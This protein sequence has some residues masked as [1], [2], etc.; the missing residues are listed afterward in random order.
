MNDGPSFDFDDLETPDA[1][2]SPDDLAILQ[3]FEA[4]QDWEHA[5][6]PA[7]VPEA[8]ISEEESFDD[9]A[10]EMLMLFIS[11]VEE[12]IA[13]MQHALAAL[14]QEDH[15]QPAHYLTLHRAG[16]KI[17]GTAG[18]ME[19]H[20]MAAI[21]HYVE[22]IV[23][24]I[25]AG[26]IF[27]LIGVRALTLA[28]QAME[29]SLNSV[30]L[31]GKEQDEPLIHFKETLAQLNIQVEEEQ[32]DAGIDRF[33]VSDGRDQPAIESASQHAPLEQAQEASSPIH[34]PSRLAPEP[35]APH[36]FVRV[37]MHRFEQL[38]HHTEH[39]AE[40]RSPLESA[41]A[42]VDEALQELHEAQARLHRL[43]D[44][45]SAL[46][47][48][49]QHSHEQ[50]E[51]PHTALVAPSLI[52]KILRDASQRVDASSLHHARKVKARPRLTRMSGTLSWDE[53]EIERYTEH[54]TLTRALNEAI[55]DVSLA[56]SRVRIAFTQLNTVLQHYT[57]RSATV[58]N[59]MLRLRLAPLSRLVPR[60]QR[61]ITMSIMP[62]QQQS[63]QFEVEGETTEVD[64]DTL[65]ALT[66][67]LLQLL[68]TCIIDTRAVQPGTEAEEAAKAERI[69]LHARGIGNEILIELGFSMPVVY[70]D[71]TAMQEE[72]QRLKGTMS[73]QAL[74]SGG[75]LF[76]LRLPRS[77][78]AVRC[79]LVR[80]GSQHLIVPF[81]QVLRIADTQRE[82]FDTLFAFHDLL[83]LPP[84]TTNVHP[85]IQPAL[86]LPREEGQ[87]SI[88]VTV[89]E[90]VNDVELIVKPLPPYLQ[91][92]GIVDA[93][94]DGKGQ[95]LLMADLP[96]LIS[97]ERTQRHETL[98]IAVRN[99]W[100]GPQ[101]GRQLTVLIADDSASM[102]RTL[103]NTLR[104]ANYKVI[105]AQDGLEAQDTLMNHPPDICLIDVE[106][107]KLT[108]Y[109]LL[110]IL[111]HSP[112]LAHTKFIMLTS[113]TSDKHRQRAQELGVHDYLTKPCSAETLLA[114]LRH[115]SQE[116]A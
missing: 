84:S 79:L 42:Q 93:A 95:A 60:L 69:W 32:E 50:A 114:T 34:L 75:F 82:Q 87:S 54:D 85:R 17:R 106:M 74:A 45:F 19:C 15:I 29:E 80:V 66:H 7:A 27:P 113:R 23:D 102:R 105:E 51:L 73:T 58:R 30:I 39:L 25:S 96:A 46:S 11:E 22:L 48:S 43:E 86:V 49:A 9:D 36:Q 31:Q 10:D 55:A 94:I 26:T 47:T 112:T 97:H 88:A 62:Q 8:S 37:D 14:E 53:L 110:S 89:D 115:L 38:V 16:H 68:R 108:G 21:A 71:L 67:L 92:P 72:I 28:V 59:D 35:P 104:H 103:S 1:T 90:V 99:S 98:R 101:E 24:Y 109:D 70:D 77:Q 41:Q 63:I 44:S 52:T 100:Q 107:P 116:R 20:A 5:Y 57:T 76:T 64:Q 111:R 2:P 13:S 91:R 3:A 56:T 65:E 6:A 78:G 83:G 61:A 18:A 81:S 33:I 4:R 40:L 12:D